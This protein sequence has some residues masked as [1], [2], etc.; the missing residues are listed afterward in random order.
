[1]FS[2]LRLKVN[3]IA[4][5]HSSCSV[6]NLKSR[7]AESLLDLVNYWLLESLLT[8]KQIPAPTHNYC[9]SFLKLFHPC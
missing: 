6:V 1:M 7:S 3:V 8:G 4:I 2:P 5:S 9:E